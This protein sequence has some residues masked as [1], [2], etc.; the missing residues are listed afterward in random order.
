MEQTDKRTLVATL[1]QILLADGS[2]VISDH[3][4]KFRTLRTRK[5]LK[6]SSKEPSLPPRK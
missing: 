6:L 4:S 5:T 1:P 3:R 2:R